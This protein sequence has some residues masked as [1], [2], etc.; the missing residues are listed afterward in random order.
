[1][2]RPAR[3]VSDEL[4]I[5]HLSDLH[6]GSPGAV[7]FWQEHLRPYLVNEL[8]PALILVSGDLVDTPR[9]S[10]FERVRHAL[11]NLDIEY[12]VCAGNHDRYWKGNRLFSPRRFGRRYVLLAS[13]ILAVVLFSSLVH[14]YSW[15]VAASI[16][17]ATPVVLWI[18]VRLLVWLFTLAAKENG[19]FEAE[20]QERIPGTR[21]IV[22][23]IG[24]GS[25]AWRVGLISVDSSKDADVSARGYVDEKFFNPIVQAT[26]NQACD[27]SIMLV[28]HHLLSIRELESKWEHDL[29]R[30]LNLTTLVNSGK[31]L[32]T[33]TKAH[34]DLVLH[35]HEHAWNGAGYSSLSAGRSG[36]KVVGA[37]S[38]TGTETGQ[39]TNPD[40]A[41]F[42]VIVLKSDRS[43]RLRK[44]GRRD[45]QW[46]DEKEYPL[47]D[48]VSLRQ[49]QLRRLGTRLTSG[50]I[51]SEIVKMVEFTRERDVWV[52]WK[53]TDWRLH[54]KEFEQPV[55]NSAG[56]IDFAEATV[57]PQDG[58]APR[59]VDVS[60]EPHPH[61]PNTWCLRWKVPEDLIDK[62]ANIDLCYVWRC[63][64]FLS[65]EELQAA[66][67]VG[68]TSSLRMR[69]Y[70]SALCKPPD[71]VA[72]L[73][74]HVTLP[75]EFAPEE[76]PIICI[77]DPPSE[78]SEG[79]E[80]LQ[81][82]LRVLAPGQFAIR[83]PFPQPGCDYCIAWKPVS[84]STIAERTDNQKFLDEFARIARDQTY[85]S[86]LLNQFLTAFSDAAYFT[87]LTASLYVKLPGTQLL[88]R[89]AVAPQA[90][91][92]CANPC[93][94]PRISLGQLRNTVVQAWY[95]VARCVDRSDSEQDA[96][97][98]GFL[99]GETT[100]MCV[101]VRFSLSWSNPS[102]WGV[103]RLA[104]G[105]STQ[106]DQFTE[107]GN[108]DKTSARLNLAAAR[109]LATALS[110]MGNSQ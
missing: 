55:R 68:A 104:V 41:S 28:H 74:M 72:A 42:N 5:V 24:N 53:Y 69:G 107:L 62:I 87:Q 61:K 57:Y 22:R 97:D 79:V 91:A 12:F 20:F 98:V 11:D 58:T 95:E 73:E 47:C 10:D 89:V 100:I 25:A 38:V 101:P 63:G 13:A 35:G 7:K 64:G 103:V 108:V 46:E 4:L 86:E 106:N 67:R 83:I 21:G 18:A 37:G 65:E 96:L 60:F 15:A 85:G 99:P 48:P 27:L 39:G 30:L 9:G 94:P 51:Q 29:G 43:V 84:E 40:H 66:G 31:F 33:L 80:E 88:E 17:V 6:F 32:E 50:R 110:T 71:T 70:E 1:M 54:F 19:G 82:Q 52:Y 2:N 45:G 78:R 36:V 3:P 75:S 44:V 102:P 93:Q 49:S 81:S 8:K 59:D 56:F 90:N 77:G 76:S 16:A 23:T 34:V 105:L 92:D 26:R 109:L 14:R